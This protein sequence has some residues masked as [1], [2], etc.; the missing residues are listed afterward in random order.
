MPTLAVLHQYCGVNTFYILISIRRRPWK[1]C[2]ICIKKI[3]HICM[4]KIGHICMTKIGHICIAKIG[5]I[6]IKKIGAKELTSIF[7]SCDLYWILYIYVFTNFR[8]LP[9]Y[10]SWTNQTSC[11]NAK[12]YSG[13]KRK[14]KGFLE[15][16]GECYK[17]SY[18]AV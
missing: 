6:C 1:I 10:A 4:T 3:G 9:T 18:T 15:S 8:C 16:S 13:K 2:H 5:H 11:T 12:V 14:R 17:K 7:W